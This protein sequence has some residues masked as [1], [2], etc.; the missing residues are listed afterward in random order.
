[1]VGILNWIFRKQVG[2][3]K[4]IHLAP[5]KYWWHAIANTVINFKI[6]HKAGH[7]LNR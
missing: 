1:M 7:F 4:C 2:D 3:K 5:D 6:P